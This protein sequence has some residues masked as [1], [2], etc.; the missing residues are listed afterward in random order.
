M[1]VGIVEEQGQEGNLIPTKDMVFC[2]KE[3]IHSENYLKET[4]NQVVLYLS[5]F[6]LYFKISSAKTLCIN[7]NHEV[8]ML[9]RCAK[10]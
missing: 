8:S 7:P 3:P 2:S 5:N 4:G 6:L 1:V 9:S 10:L